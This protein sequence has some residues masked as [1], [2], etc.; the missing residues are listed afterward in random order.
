MWPVSLE[1]F[2][3]QKTIYEQ[4]LRLPPKVVLWFVPFSDERG[5]FQ[6]APEC[7]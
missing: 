3:S 2:I 6:T 4:N 1:K 7:E 5:G